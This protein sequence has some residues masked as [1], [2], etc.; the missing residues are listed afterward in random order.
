MVMHQLSLTERRIFTEPALQNAKV[1]QMISLRQLQRSYLER[2]GAERQTLKLFHQAITR[3]TEFGFLRSGDR[4]RGD[5]TY[6]IEA[7]WP[8]AS[9]FA[10]KSA[11]EARPVDQCFL[12]IT[13]EERA[14][15]QADSPAHAVFTTLRPATTHAAVPGIMVSVR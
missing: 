14:R 1:G 3:L 4:K 11:L 6:F 7:D 12:S 8:T 15:H 13:A 5:R 2:F 10:L 9:A